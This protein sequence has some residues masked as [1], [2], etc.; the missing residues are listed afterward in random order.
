MVTSSQRLSIASSL[1]PGFSELKDMRRKVFGL[2]AFA[3]LDR[4]PACVDA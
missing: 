4:T 3:H 2:E 1:L